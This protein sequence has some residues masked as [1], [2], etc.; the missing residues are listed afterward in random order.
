M[1]KYATT[2]RQRTEEG[3][4]LEDAQALFHHHP[5]GEILT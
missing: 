5:N 2:V 4:A 3:C 1:A